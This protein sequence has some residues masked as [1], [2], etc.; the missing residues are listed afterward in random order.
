MLLPSK[1]VLTSTGI[2]LAVL[3]AA[4]IGIQYADFVPFGNVFEGKVLDCVDGD[5][6]NVQYLGGLKTFRLRLQGIDSPEDGQDFDEES[7]RHLN[8]LV[9]GKKVEVHKVNWT[10]T[11]TKNR[12]NGHLYFWSGNTKRNAATAH[13]ETGLAVAEVRWLDEEPERAR[14]YVQSQLLAMQEKHGI[15]KDDKWRSPHCFRWAA[16]EECKTNP[17]HQPE[18]SQYIPDGGTLALSVSE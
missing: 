3:V 8:Y 17:Q 7:K 18:V 1:A 2:S 6:C 14:E 4:Y 15:F 12:M 13:L 5:E 10:H 9:A 16:K 11:D